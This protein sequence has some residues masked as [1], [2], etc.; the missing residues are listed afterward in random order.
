[1]KTQFK[2]TGMDCESCKTIIEDIAKDFPE[3]KNCQVDLSS[4]MGSIEYKDGFDLKKFQ[5][6]I[7]GIGKYKLDFI[8]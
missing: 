7:D 3:I 6:E 4:G 5:S 8:S 1:M 2:V